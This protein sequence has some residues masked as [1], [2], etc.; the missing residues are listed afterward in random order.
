MNRCPFS[1]VLPENIASV[2]S[3]DEIFED[4]INIGLNS[5]RG[6]S[7]LSQNQLFFYFTCRINKFFVGASDVAHAQ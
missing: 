1:H 7:K 6:I 3:F 5:P 4:Y 2:V